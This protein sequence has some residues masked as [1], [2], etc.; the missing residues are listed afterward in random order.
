MLIGDFIFNANDAPAA[1]DP[2]DNWRKNRDQTVHA[3][4]GEV[5]APRADAAT[6]L[7]SQRVKASTNATRERVCCEH[8]DDLGVNQP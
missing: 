7:T 5:A 8:L 1:A 2:W 3:P 4:A 6:A